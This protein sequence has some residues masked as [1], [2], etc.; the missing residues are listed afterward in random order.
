MLAFLSRKNWL[1]KGRVPYIIRRR[2]EAKGE[3]RI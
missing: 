2:H 3:S 1:E